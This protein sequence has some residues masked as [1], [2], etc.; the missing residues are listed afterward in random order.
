MCQ[1]LLVGGNHDNKTKGLLSWLMLLSLTS[2][3]LRGTDVCKGHDKPK[4]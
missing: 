4:P 1:K 2:I 3:V